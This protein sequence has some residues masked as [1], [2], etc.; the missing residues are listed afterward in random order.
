MW[1]TEDR[2]R[3]DRSRP[4]YPS[5]M[6]DAEWALIAEMIPPAKRGGKARTVNLREVVNGL[7]YVLGAGCQWR[8]IPKDLR[9]RSTLHGYVLRREWDGTLGRIHH[10]LDGLRHWRMPRLSPR[11]SRM[12]RLSGRI[13]GRSTLLA[14]S[15]AHR[16][17]LRPD[18]RAAHPPWANCLW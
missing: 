11:P 5:D 9:P 12:R 1:T 3:Y 17:L 14:G 13:G 4:R 6:T 16:L 8:A 10:A 15:P 7:L 18:R 2:S